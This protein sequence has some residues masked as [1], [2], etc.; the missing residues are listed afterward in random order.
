MAAWEQDKAWS[1]KFL[2]EI[3]G[4]LGRLL[5]S[6]SPAIEDKQ[7]NTD[8]IVLKLESVRIACRVR[9]FKYFDSYS[10]ELTIRSSRPGADTELRKIIEGWGDYFFYGFADQEDSRLVKW[11]VVDLKKFR[12]WFCRQ[13]C[14]LQGKTPGSE[15][16][17][18]DGSSKFLVFKVEEL[19]DAIIAQSEAGNV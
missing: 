9:K 11:I 15:R 8:L 4:I 18:S 2:D 14:K 5:I 10:D 6:A 19:K 17:N 3:K 13:L 16:T 12:L 1:D 7:H